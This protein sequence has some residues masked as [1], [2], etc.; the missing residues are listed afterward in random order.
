LLF[1]AAMLRAALL[2]ALLLSLHAGCNGGT[3]P[4]A[5]DNNGWCTNDGPSGPPPPQIRY[6]TVG[7]VPDGD[8][9]TIAYLRHEFQDESTTIPN[10]VHLVR[11]DSTGTTELG[12][13][14]RDGA[15]LAPHDARL[16]AGPRGA[17]ITWVGETDRTLYAG[18]LV[19][20]EILGTVAIGTAN[21]QR[22]DVVVAD[23][24]F[25]IIWRPISSSPLTLQRIDANAVPIGERLELDQCCVTFAS[26]GTD[27]I[28][29]WLAYR[30]SPLDPS[31]LVAR[32]IP[33]MGPPLPD[34]T[35]VENEFI[36]SKSPIVR[37]SNGYRLFYRGS[38]ADG[39][40]NTWDL[41][42]DSD[43][44]VSKLPVGPADAPAI[45]A[46][47]NVHF[48]GSDHLIVSAVGNINFEDIE[49]RLVS[50]A[51]T[52]TQGPGRLEPDTQADIDVAIGEAGYAVVYA[53]P[54]DHQYGIRT[55]LV[56]STLAVGKP[57]T[58]AV[59]WVGSRAA[60]NASGTTSP[61]VFL[62]LL[63][64]TARR[65]RRRCDREV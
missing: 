34:I 22:P 48:T 56:H 32:R 46:I 60:C 21:G 51:A 39:A 3:C 61:L 13:V 55:A 16:V 42:I 20:T 30:D 26:D 9:Y 6:G 29:T 25:L 59:D 18:R 31:K 49:L 12:L 36:D 50:D 47:R 7:V 11:L 33:A 44:T 38:Y 35:V 53:A 63:G 54:V 1:V 14:Q 5:D 65:R 45:N 37:D 10:E 19:G 64:L 41:R 57:T 8:G 52:I 62:A 23:N 15:P 28:A 17:L 58:L 2:A 4:E 40:D 27:Y 43:G 24:G